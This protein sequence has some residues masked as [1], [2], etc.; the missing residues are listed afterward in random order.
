MPEISLTDFVDFVAKNGTPR[1]NHV[2]TLKH[3]QAYDPAQDFWRAM[4]DGIIEYHRTSQT[5]KSWLDGI[6]AG[7]ADRKKQKNYPNAISSYKKF[8]GRKTITWFQTRPQRWSHGGIDIRINPELGLEINGTRHHLKLYFKATPLRKDKADM[9]ILLMK[10][11]LN[12][13]HFGD[14]LAILDIQTRKLFCNAQPDKSLLPLLQ[15]E[16]TALASIWNSI[17]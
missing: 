9:I 10:E 1:L 15:G 17:P 16:A 4:R 12:G 14:N 11:A 2:R 8:L 13:V 3:R 5:S 6:T 7:L